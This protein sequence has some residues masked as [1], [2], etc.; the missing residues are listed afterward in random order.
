MMDPFL[1]LQ[2]RHSVF[3]YAMVRVLATIALWFSAADAPAALRTE[4]PSGSQ[5]RLWIALAIMVI[6]GVLMLI[7]Q[8][9]NGA[10]DLLA[11]LGFTRGRLV[12][13]AVGP[14]I[15]GE[16]LLNLVLSSRG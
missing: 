13:I 15:V 3:V 1:R 14:A 5:E 16:L 12:L 7:D 6:T 9:R 2:L 8:R 11:N 4:G 10:P